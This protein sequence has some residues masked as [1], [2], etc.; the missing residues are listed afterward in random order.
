MDALKAYL[1]ENK[2]SPIA[3]YYLGLAYEQLH[4]L[5]NAEKAYRK[6]ILAQP[7]HIS[8]R[9][10]LGVVLEQLNK[11]DEALSQYQ[12]IIRATRSR[13]SVVFSKDRNKSERF[14]LAL[15]IAENRVDRL[16]KHVNGFSYRLGYVLAYDTNTNLSENNAIEE[17]RSDT[18]GSA[19]YS[20]KLSR[21]LR[22]NFSL[23]PSYTTYHVRR[24]DFLTMSYR[25]FL[26]LGT[27]SNYIRIGGSKSD[28]SGVLVDENLSSRVESYVIGSFRGKVPK[29]MRGMMKADNKDSVRATYTFNL[30]RTVFD[31]NDS[32]VFDAASW[33]L[34]LGMRMPNFLGFA[35]ASFGVEYEDSENTHRQGDD[36]AYVMYK[37]NFR[38]DKPLT[39]EFSINSSIDLRF[40]E[41]QNDDSNFE[42]KRSKNEQILA[43]GFTYLYKLKVRFFGSY[44]V[45]RSESSIPVIGE[46]IDPDEIVVSQ[47]SNVLG[48]YIKQV[49]SLGLTLSF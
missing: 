34:N 46:D 21:F 39:R 36:Y 26:E 32:Q 15:S 20:L 42:V 44:R 12:A 41:Y 2:G 37:Y 35:N 18:F 40:R 27:R 7:G 19:S 28:L 9:I 24:S 6:T 5:K 1:V 33:R 25:P 14:D 10:R 47:Q 16:Q 23:A 11:E 48:S 45:T 29:F 8:A 30:N 43:F 13:K 4:Q 17:F 31:A 22:F 3:N 38:L 49:Y